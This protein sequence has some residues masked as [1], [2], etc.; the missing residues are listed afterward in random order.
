M[1]S[2]RLSLTDGHALRHVVVAN[3]AG[4]LHSNQLAAPAPRTSTWSSCVPQSPSCRGSNRAGTG[5]GRLSG[6]CAASK[7]GKQALVV[8]WLS[9][10]P[11][12]KNTHTHKNCLAGS[13][14]TPPLHAPQHTILCQVHV[15]LKCRQVVLGVETIEVAAQRLTLCGGRVV[16]VGGWVVG[17]VGEG[18]RHEQQASRAAMHVRQSVCALLRLF[19]FPAS[20]FG[21]RRTAKLLPLADAPRWQPSGRQRKHRAAQ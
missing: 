10:W 17:W 12:P 13:P 11:P 18:S 15:C 14:P 9:C 19:G 8:P 21:R 2:A 6:R 20:Q 7:Q 4:A 16:V 1:G 3:G 5:Q